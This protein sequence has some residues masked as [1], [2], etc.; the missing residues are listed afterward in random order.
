MHIA[1][2]FF[3]EVLNIAKRDNTPI[4][5]RIRAKQVLVIGPKGEQV[6]QKSVE[7]ALTLASYAGFDL[8]QMGKGDMPTCKLMDYNKYKYERNKKKKESQK[9]QRENNAAVKE[10]R[11]GYQIDIHDFN[12][13]VKNARKYAEKG[14]KIKASLRFKGRAIIHQS[15][16][17]EVLLRFAEA[18]SDLSEI[19]QKP[20]LDNRSMIMLLTPKKDKD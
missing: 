14:H 19:E 9:K 15:I 5:E 10:F 8:V 7:E 6:G 16:G 20:T 3:L 2:T 17:E 12:T 18:L 1:F 11:L 13:R 4:N